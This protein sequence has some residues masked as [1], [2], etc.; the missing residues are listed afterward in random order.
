MD[1]KVNDEMA[2]IA[3]RMSTQREFASVGNRPV[4]NRGAQGR[5]P[6]RDPSEIHHPPPE[7][8]HPAVESEL[9]EARG[10]YNAGQVERSIRTDLMQWQGQVDDLIGPGED[11]AQIIADT[12]VS[13]H[14]GNQV[15]QLTIMYDALDMPIPDEDDP[16]YEEWLEF[17]FEEAE[18][19]FN[20]IADQLN[21]R[22]KLPGMVSFGW[23]QGYY[24][25]YRWDPEDHPELMEQR[26]GSLDMVQ[27]ALKSVG[28]RQESVQEEYEEDDVMRALRKV[29]LTSI[30]EVDHGIRRTREG[31]MEQYSSITF[32]P[33]DMARLIA[34][35]IPGAEDRGANTKSDR[36]WLSLSEPS[37]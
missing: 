16:E 22:M 27:D 36:V 1:V 2:T 18:E 29:D 35:M 19:S 31:G 20:R 24:M 33:S 10:P 15:D 14:A 12:V 11:E 17:G 26:E 7:Q 30:V 5:E 6:D 37:G 23:D 13:E 4:R 32:K 21:S 28:D 3:E 34:A 9:D 25:F 8:E